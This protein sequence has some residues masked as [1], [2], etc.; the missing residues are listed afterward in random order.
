MKTSPIAVFLSL[1]I[2]SMMLSP[3]F[4][5]DFS[6][7]TRETRPM[8]AVAVVASLSGSPKRM[9][10]SLRFGEA[11]PAEGVEISH[12]IGESLGLVFANQTSIYTNQRS[13]WFVQKFTG[14]VA[15][16]EDKPWLVEGTQSEL[17]IEL[18]EGV[19]AFSAP[20]LSPLSIFKIE[21]PHGALLVSK[22]IGIVRVSGRFVSVSMMHGQAWFD[23]E[24][25]DNPMYISDLDSIDLTDTS[26]I[27]LDRV[28]RTRWDIS[29]LDRRKMGIAAKN[30]ERVLF[31]KNF[32]DLSWSDQAAYF[33]TPSKEDD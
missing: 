14:K 2:V 9:S 27:H 24:Y 29:D 5:Q 19:M 15:K 17:V 26:S 21:T 30:G 22:G 8:E 32:L 1:L 7:G 12:G 31:T 6:Y 23:N 4:G 20:H 28:Q 25:S 13:E 18:S 33:L 16:E 11:F 10:R 3:L